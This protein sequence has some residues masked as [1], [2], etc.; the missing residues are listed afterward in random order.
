VGGRRG[1]GVWERIGWWIGGYVGV[2]R[3]IEHWHTK[4]HQ[5]FGIQE[6]IEH[7]HTQKHR[8]S[9]DGKGSSFS[10]QR[11]IEHWGR[12]RHRA[13]YTQSYLHTELGILRAIPEDLLK[14]LS[15]IVKH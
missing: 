1:F 12:H 7:W 5:V 6:G 10:K 11:G 9:A 15:S 2:Q 13:T 8:A 3:R 4:G 14:S